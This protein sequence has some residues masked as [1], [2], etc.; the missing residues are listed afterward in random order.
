MLDIDPDNPGL[1]IWQGH[2]YVPCPA[3]SSLRDAVTGEILVG[4]PSKD[5][6]GRAM[7]SDIDPRFPGCE[8]WTTESEG[9]LSCKGEVI[10]PKTPS[11]NMAIWWDGDLT[12]ELQDGIM[13]DKW[14]GHG[15]TNLFNGKDKGIASNNGTKANPCLIA[16]IFGDWREEIIWRSEDN[17][18]IRIYMT[19]FST[20]YRF[21]S[22]M[23]DPIYRWG[24]ISHNVGYNQP[25]HTGF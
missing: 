21:P 20:A 7:C 17:S 22:F 16:D 3:G 6:V 18:E 1:E 19:P 11:I 2:E 14:N 8:I 13:I 12:R 4:I 5:D 23:E 15:V 9:V 10:Y 24:V 25:N